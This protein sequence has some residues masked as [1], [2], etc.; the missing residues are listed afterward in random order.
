MLLWLCPPPELPPPIGIGMPPL[1]PDEDEP[2]DILPGMPGSLM[3]IFKPFPPG[4]LIVPSGG[5]VDSSKMEISPPIGMPLVEIEGPRRPFC[6]PLL[7]PAPF[8]PASKILGSA[9][10]WAWALSASSIAAPSAA[11]RFR[12][13]FFV[14][15]GVR[16]LF[17][18]LLIANHRERRLS[19]SA[20][21]LQAVGDVLVAFFLTFNA[22]VAGH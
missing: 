3:G 22:I 19:D 13:I 7:G 20:F 10:N 16:G 1:L 14:F 17:L 5:S 15:M 2:P 6:W 18:S 8:A 21:Y 11:L 4:M 12:D 9:S